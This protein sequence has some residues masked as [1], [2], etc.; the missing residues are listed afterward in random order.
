MSLEMS[1]GKFP[2]RFNIAVENRLNIVNKQHVKNNFGESCIHVVQ[3]VLGVSFALRQ[4]TK[5]T[6]S[7]K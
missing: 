6:F 4:N 7:A 5:I 2:K 1:D 3:F